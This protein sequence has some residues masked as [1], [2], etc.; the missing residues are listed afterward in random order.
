MSSIIPAKDVGRVILEDL[1][2]MALR[3]FPDATEADRELM[4]AKF[5]G[6]W[7]SAMFKGPAKKLHKNNS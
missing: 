4:I 2:A 6:V 5:L 7:G 3:D 1:R